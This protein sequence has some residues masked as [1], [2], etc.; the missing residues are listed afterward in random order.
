MLRKHNFFSNFPRCANLIEHN[1][2]L[3]S[4]QPF[5]IKTYQISARST[6]ILK[7]EI[8]L[9]FYFK[10]IEAGKSDCVVQRCRNGSETLYWLQKIKFNDPN[11]ISSITKHWAAAKYIKF[12]DLTKGNFQMPLLHQGRKGKLLLRSPLEHFIHWSCHLGLWM[13]YLFSKFMAEL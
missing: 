5:W 4:Y 2:E 6:K 13:H 11:W 1:I 10:I 12:T 8:K 3:I 7:Q 9:V